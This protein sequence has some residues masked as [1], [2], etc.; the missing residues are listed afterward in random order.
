MT[1]ERLIWVDRM[2]GLAILSVVIQHLTYYYQNDFMYHKLIGI[3]NMSIFFFISGFIWAKTARI[4][5]WNDGLHYVIKKTIQLM[6]PFIVWTFIVAPYFFQTNWE[7]WTFAKIVDEFVN[8]HLWFLLTLYGYTFYF[9]I[10]KIF[11]KQGG[12]KTG[13]LF[14]MTVL[15]I[16]TA[17]WYK[18]HMFKLATLYLPYFALGT[19]VS[20]KN[21]TEKLAS[22]RIL[23]TLSLLS[24]FLLLGYWESGH[25]S[26][27]NIGIKLIV[28]LSMILVTYAVCNKL[29]WNKYFDKFIL[30]CGKYSLAIY[31]MHWSFLHIIDEKP[32][33]VQ[34]E[35]IA[36]IPMLIIAILIC[37]TC[38]LFKNIIALFPVAD[39]LLF[40]NYK[41]QKS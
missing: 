2:R 11:N 19:L 34:N 12:V 1:G 7:T 28:S 39:F 33:I 8:P 14:W 5:T 4:E 15:F 37:Y 24:V 6:L 31:I 38:V 10:F 23:S 17:I 35:L 22:N 21:L 26:L 29:N 32:L 25:T 36:F 20:Q 18:W 3:V 41:K 16:L 30:M 40:G 27:L 13:I 9:V